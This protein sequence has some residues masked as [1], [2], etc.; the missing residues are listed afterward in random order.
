MSGS[1]FTSNSASSNGG[2]IRNVGTLTQSGN[3]F[4]GNSP[5]D[6]D[7]GVDTT[8]PTA[9]ILD[10]T[11]DP[12]NT[13]VDSITLVFSEPVT[14]LD[15]ADLRLTRDGGGNLLTAAQTLTTADNVTWTLVNLAGLTGIG[16]LCAA[17]I[18]GAMAG[19][20]P[21]LY[22]L[23]GVYALY[24]Q[25]HGPALTTPWVWPARPPHDLGAAIC[26]AAVFVAGLAAAAWRG[27]R[28]EARPVSG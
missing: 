27:S 21:T 3:T 15:R 8:A 5:N 23:V 17:L 7:L 25:W 12:R 28:D 13:A 10:V 11:P 4:T 24:L 14:G 9:D 22:M 19:T 16:L 18:G 1:T 20:G 2:G 26:A 6:V